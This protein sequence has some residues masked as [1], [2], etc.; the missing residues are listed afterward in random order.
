[1]LMFLDD[2]RAPFG[3]RNVGLSPRTNFLLK[4]TPQPV[5][6][7]VRGGKGR[8]WPGKALMQ[9]KAVV[10]DSSKEQRMRVDTVPLPE[11]RDKEVVRFDRVLLYFL[12]II[13]LVQ[14]RNR[15]PIKMKVGK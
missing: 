11:I 10:H 4:N 13:F 12:C 8:F 3:T 1:M 2:E 14:H 6:N 15:L 5:V 9:R 7:L